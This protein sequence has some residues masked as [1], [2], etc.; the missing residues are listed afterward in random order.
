MRLL[1]GLVLSVCAFFTGS[2]WAEMPLTSEDVLATSAKYAPM[3]LESLARQRVAEGQ[4][5]SAEGSFDTIAKSDSF[6][7]FSGFWDGRIL[8]TEVEQRLRNVGATVFGGYKLSDGS[9]PIYEDINF[10]NTGGEIKGGFILSLLRDRAFDQQRAGLADASIGLSDADI[11]LMVA[12]IGVQHRALT[13][14][15]TWLASGTQLAIY[16]NLLNIAL[17][18]E[19]GLERRVEEGDVAEILI[20]E[21]RQNILRRQ[22]L[23]VESQRQLKASALAL[24]MFYRDTVGLPIEPQETQL[25]EGF[26]ELD[27]RVPATDDEMIAATQA[28]RP[29]LALLDNNL[30]KAQIDLRLAENEMKPRLD[31][32][33]EVSRDFG[34]VAEGGISRDSTDNILAVVFRL[35]IQRRFA[36]GRMQSARAE[37]QAL[38]FRR[39]QLEETIAIEIRTLR[40]D[41]EAAR[42]MVGLAVEEQKQAETMQRVER[43]RFENG[44]SDFFL[45]NMR[46][47]RAA[48][49]QVRRVVAQLRYFIAQA[50]YFAA[51]VD[52][53]SLGLATK[54]VS[55]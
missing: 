49:A 31:F 4:A 52:L 46:E 17:E 12:R 45:L 18:R 8:Q 39:Q 24:S 40:N 42:A 25:P 43:T 15:Y 47:E 23:V 3:I 21:N 37:M 55:E 22:T 51:I 26:P 36:K 32:R 7:R 6:G 14:Y 10:T 29:E 28:V 33:Y 44:I 11:N 50:N 1:K 48:D 35:P 13:T 30:A 53:P 34:A 27:D 38:E 41:F 9:F 19:K 5:L 20:V 16:R 54:P 2:A